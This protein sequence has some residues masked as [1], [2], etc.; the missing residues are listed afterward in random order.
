M[1]ADEEGTLERLKTLRRELIDVK[2]GQHRGRIVKTTGD[3]L[4]VEF[5]S[6]VD[7]VRCAAEVQQ[8]MP[9]RNARVPA[10]RRIEL[11]IGINL[12]DV[13]ADGD[14]LFGDGVNIAARIEALADAGSVFV[15]G[16]AHEHVRDRLPFGLED[17]GERQLKNI[18]RPIR[19]YR[20]LPDE[21]TLIASAQAQASLSEKPSIAV[22]PFQNLSSDPEQEYF[23][24]GIAEDIITDL[25]RNRSLFVIARNSSFAFK[26]R[27]VD[28]RQVERELSVRYVLEGSVRR[29]AGRVRVV[30]QLIDAETGNHIW[31]GRYDRAIED[32]FAVQD[33]ITVAVVTAIVP[34]VAD[35]ELRRALRKP[36]E[37]LGAWEAYQRGLWHYGKAIPAD[38]KRARKYFERAIA[39]D[40]TFAAA[41]SHL[42]LTHVTEGGVLATR[43][44]DEAV[45]LAAANAR[46][47]VEYDPN[48]GDALAT[49]AYAAFATGDRHEARKWAS[50]A[51]ECGTN[52]AWVNGIKGALLVWSGDTAEGRDR[53]RIAL[54]LNPHDP[55]NRLFASSIAASYYME[56]DYVG[57][58]EA[59]KWAITTYPAYPNPY[60]WLAASLGQIGNIDEA[61]KALTQAMTVSRTAFDLHVRSIP[62]WFLPEQHKHLLDGLRKAGWQG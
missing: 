62:A 59:A 1:G 57:A 41:Y 19:I 21:L 47:A 54:R 22:L 30:A 3:G 60:R 9:G 58:I 48:D 5:A 51:D 17:M 42:A 18:A 39:L 28:I 46:R 33:E 29:N 11:R 16:T 49:L 23:S 24:D 43:P 55:R 37:N 32:V 20:V 44:A 52:S 7:A 13:I 12:G 14:D 25:S 4:L 45:R 56:H 38:N 10:D 34:A 36:P 6:V 31:A 50:L 15:S 35:A 61:R 27:A 53:M 2:I 40:G 26:G 8:A